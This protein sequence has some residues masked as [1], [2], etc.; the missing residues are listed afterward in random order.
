[1]NASL[2]KFAVLLALVLLAGAARAQ[3]P[4]GQP[5]TAS[6]PATAN[7]GESLLDRAMQAID[8][9]PTITAK[10][11]HMVDLGARRLVGTGLYLQQGRG[12][13]RAFRL[14][15]EFQTSTQ[16]AAIQQIC[17]GANLWFYQQLQ[18]Q[19]DLAWVDVLRLARARPRTN[20]TVQP[21]NLTGGLPR[22][23]SG[24][25]TA[26]QFGA[27]SEARLEDVRAW[28][29]E[30]D[31]EPS[32]LSGMFPDQSEAIRGGAKPDL[33]KLALNLPDRVVLYVGCDDLLPYRIEYW[34]SQANAAADS[35]NG[36]GKLIGLFELYELRIDAPIDPAQFVCRHGNL[37]PVDR[38]AEYLEKL[39][40]EDQL[41]AGANRRNL[42]RR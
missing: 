30:G 17:D 22:M 4:P 41:P 18:G 37:K 14:D 33:S 3:T 28:A 26:F 11:R 42:R 6:A 29:T 32:R 38:T 39:G 8:S 1:M 12:P 20:A 5:Q 7:A 40:L 25:Q 19:E 13:A 10:V 21:W 16:P 9:R 27:V 23:L 2:P 35:A 36:R 31:W 24:L 15:L 34:R